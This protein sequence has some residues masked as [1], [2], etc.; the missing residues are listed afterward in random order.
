[1]I[2][3]RLALVVL[4]YILPVSFVFCNLFQFLLDSLPPIVK[5]GIDLDI[6]EPSLSADHSVHV[7]NN[8]LLLSAFLF[9][10]TCCSALDAREG[11]DLFRTL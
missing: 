7:R 3:A 9:L 2:P 1:M 11:H 5:G 6:Q 8:I 4:H 10:Y